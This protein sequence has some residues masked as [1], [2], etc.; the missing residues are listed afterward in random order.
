MDHKQRKHERKRAV[1]TVLVVSALAPLVIDEVASLRERGVT[2][3]IL[4]GHP[5]ISKELLVTASDMSECLVLW[6]LLLEYIFYG[7]FTEN[8]VHVW[9]VCTMTYFADIR[10]IGVGMERAIPFRGGS[11]SI[12]HSLCLFVPCFSKWAP[13]ERVIYEKVF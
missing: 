7:D 1:V 11:Y 13:I 3:W 10:Q 6:R 12:H 4:S 8:C 5:R 9:P 2:E